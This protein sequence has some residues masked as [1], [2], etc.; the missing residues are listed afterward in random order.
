MKENELVRILNL[1]SKKFFRCDGIGTC[2]RFCHPY[3]G[4]E[5]SCM[6][7]RMQRWTASLPTLK[8]ILS[9]GTAPSSPCCLGQG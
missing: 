3:P 6:R 4:L 8:A 2:T 9:K 1:P 7:R 5:R